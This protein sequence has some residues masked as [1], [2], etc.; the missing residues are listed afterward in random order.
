MLWNEW[1][2]VEWV[3]MMIHYL[4]SYFPFSIFHGVTWNNT[5]SSR[6]LCIYHKSLN[7]K[8]IINSLSN[9]YP[10]CVT[11]N[12]IKI[13]TLCS[14]ETIWYYDYVHIYPVSGWTFFYVYLLFFHSFCINENH[15]IPG[16]TETMGY[17][18]SNLCSV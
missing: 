18:I 10:V 11:D 12:P 1:R 15:E 7:N 17:W 5:I 4:F 16:K 6:I 13:H 3:L 2:D 8:L 14:T 9:L